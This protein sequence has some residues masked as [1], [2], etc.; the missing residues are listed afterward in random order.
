MIDLV[1]ATLAELGT[2]RALVLHGAGGLDEISLA[3]ETQIAEVRRGAVRRFTVMP[4]DFGLSRAPLQALSG[5]TPAENAALILR[6]FHDA[7]GPPR[8]IVVANAAAALVVTNHADDFRAAAEIASNAIRSGA[9]LQ[10]LEQL[11]T[12]SLKKSR[13]IVNLARS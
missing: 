4:E 7:P 9:A 3:G 6:I 2:E 13:V 8:D 10:K 12:F 5:G 1:A 11:K